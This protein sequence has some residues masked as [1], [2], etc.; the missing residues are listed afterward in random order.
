MAGSN[1]DP[2]AWLGRLTER[3]GHIKFPSGVIGKSSY[4][5]IALLIVLAVIAYRMPP[6]WFNPLLF[7]GL[8]A[9]AVVVWWVQSTQRF[10]ERN[11]GQAMLDGAEFLDYY[12][13]EVQAKGHLHI[14]P[15]PLT[16]DPNRSAPPQLIDDRADQ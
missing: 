2:T 3:F 14:D 6:S 12:K 15:T 9:I 10:A 5:M 1:D 11:P 4:V 16:S 13:F 8:L 7:L